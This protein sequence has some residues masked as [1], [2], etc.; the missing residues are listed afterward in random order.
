MIDS[1]HN[2]STKDSEVDSPKTSNYDECVEALSMP[3]LDHTTNECYRYLKSCDKTWTFCPSMLSDTLKLHLESKFDSF[4]PESEGILTH[5]QILRRLENVDSL[6]RISD[7]KK[8]E[9]RLRLLSFLKNCGL[10]E[11]GIRRENWVE[12]NA[13]LAEAERERR[14]RGL[15]RHHLL[16]EVE[17]SKI[18]G[19]T[20]TNNDVITI[21]QSLNPFYVEEDQDY[22]NIFFHLLEITAKLNRIYRYMSM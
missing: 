14:K 3:T 9:L 5:D 10:D 8:A 11:C 16:L 12:A 4:D 1:L 18:L 15:S 13:C 19:D 2:E 20:C 22:G 7:E 6:S 21:I 17:Y